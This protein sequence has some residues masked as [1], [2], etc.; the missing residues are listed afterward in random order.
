MKDSCYSIKDSWDGKG[1]LG[2]S[3]EGVGDS[4]VNVFKCTPILFIKEE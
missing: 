4:G 3:N 1:D 2:D